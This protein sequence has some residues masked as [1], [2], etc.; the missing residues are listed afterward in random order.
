MASSSVPLNVNITQFQGNMARE[1]IIM[2]RPISPNLHVSNKGT[3]LTVRTHSCHF[4][5]NTIIITCE[6]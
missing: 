4:F 2:Q 6:T 5:P 1:A 3:R